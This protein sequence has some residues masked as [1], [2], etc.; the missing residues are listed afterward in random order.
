[1]TFRSALQAPS[2]DHSLPLLLDSTQVQLANEVKI[3]GMKLGC[4]ARHIDFSIR[5]KPVRIIPQDHDN[6]PFTRRRFVR[7]NPEVFNQVPSS[8]SLLTI[9]IMTRKDCK[10]VAKKARTPCPYHIANVR[11]THCV[12]RMSALRKKL[13]LGHISAQPSAQCSRRIP[14]PP[15][16]HGSPS[17]RNVP[18]FALTPRGKI[19]AFY[20]HICLRSR[21]AA[22]T[23]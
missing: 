5:H 2:S 21:E 23:L 19:S 16:T 14:D 11:S 8:S 12:R 7:R 20:I 15:A 6:N 17:A 3:P 9:A 22:S 4:I 18:E 10:V 13:G 1:M